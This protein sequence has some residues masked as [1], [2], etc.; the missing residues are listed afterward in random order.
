M[1]RNFPTKFR[2]SR[3]FRVKSKIFRS[4][5]ISSREEF[6]KKYRFIRK[7]PKRPDFVRKIPDLFRTSGMDPE[8]LGSIPDEGNRGY[9]LWAWGRSYFTSF[10]SLTT[11]LPSI[12][13]IAA[14]TPTEGV[15]SV[16]SLRSS[17][18]LVFDLLEGDLPKESLW[19]HG[20]G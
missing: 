12:S 9:N 8:I 2:T 16:Q 1:V 11:S 19:C 17:P 6:R 5:P 18:S 10:F 15:A 7:Y 14:A 3:I 4:D 13:F 20:F